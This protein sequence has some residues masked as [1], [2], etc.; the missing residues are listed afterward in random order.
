MTTVYKSFSADVEMLGERSI[1]AIC[2][3]ANVDMMGEVVEQEGADLSVYKRNPIV[4]FSHNPEHPV[5]A[6]GNVRVEN[7]KLLADIEFAPLGISQKADETC[8]MVKAGILKSISIGFD[9]TDSEPMNPSRPRGPQRYK[10]WTLA[11][12]SIVA[13]PANNDAVV[14]AK[15]LETKVKTKSTPPLVFKGLYG[16]GCLAELMSEL[17]WQHQMSVMEAACEED[18]SELPGK[19]GDILHSLGE[20]LIAMTQEEVAECLATIDGVESPDATD[21]ATTPALRK[22]RAG[23]SVMKAGRAVSK[24]TAETLQDSLDSH[25]ALHGSLLHHD[26]CMKAL[27]T[28]QTSAGQTPGTTKALGA[29]EPG[30]MP[31]VA[32]PQLDDAKDSH[33]AVNANAVIHAKCMKALESFIPGAGGDTN[34]DSTVSQSTPEGVGTTGNKPKSLAHLA[35]KESRQRRARALAMGA[36]VA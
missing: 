17:G 32:N 34:D 4:L 28:A 6:A 10:K 25:A 8:A 26:K 16:V 3:T 21:K 7:G 13:I 36:K 31:S 5:G 9:P 18:E 14:T 12:I 11:E 30:I 35:T 23:V 15:A 2:S 24:A 29:A 33:A 1:R 27:F 20:A 19:L 22:F